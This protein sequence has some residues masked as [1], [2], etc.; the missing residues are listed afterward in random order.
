M[1]L[2]FG[3]PSSLIITTVGCPRKRGNFTTA[4][5]PFIAGATVRTLGLQFS[6][7]INGFTFL[8]SAGAMAYTALSSWTTSKAAT[9]TQDS[10]SKQGSIKESIAAVFRQPLLR[11]Y[12]TAAVM[13]GLGYGVLHYLVVYA[14]SVLLG[15]EATYGALLAALGTGGLMSLAL[16][17]VPVSRV[18]PFRGYSVALM[19]DAV[20]FLGLGL[21]PMPTQV[22]AAVLFLSGGNDALASVS[23]ETIIQRHAGAQSSAQAFAL[24]AALSRLATPVG[25]L[26][27]GLVADSLGMRFA[28]SMSAVILGAAAVSTY[29]VREVAHSTPPPASGSPGSG[30][31]DPPPSESPQGA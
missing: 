31:V 13:S 14:N 11:R 5:G 19:M 9:G 6:T 8:V 21:F 24:D 15:D 10:S 30:G 27:T 22:A 28:F 3:H 2:P 4:I 17:I 12:Y 29:L 7:Q 20:A 23:S 1:Y 18:R 26:A 16:L 25:I